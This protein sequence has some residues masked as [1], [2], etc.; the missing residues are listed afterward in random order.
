MDTAKSVKRS[1]AS[2]PL[3]AGAALIAIGVGMAV[4]LWSAHGSHAPAGSAVGPV[5]P[6]ESRKLAPSR[7][8]CGTLDAALERLDARMHR[9]Y[10]A[11][12]GDYLRAERQRL[13]DARAGARCDHQ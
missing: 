6:P 9:G 10:A 5:A 4:P 3:V 11:A 12:E 2:L 8:Q 1:N 7:V 13:V